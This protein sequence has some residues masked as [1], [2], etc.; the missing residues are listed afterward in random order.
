MKNI[1]LEKKGGFEKTIFIFQ[2]KYFLFVFHKVQK[3]K[4]QKNTKKLTLKKQIKNLGLFFSKNKKNQ[5]EWIRELEEKSP[6]S[7]KKT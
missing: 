1:V 3:V 5:K 6:V 4:T 7:I 2:Q